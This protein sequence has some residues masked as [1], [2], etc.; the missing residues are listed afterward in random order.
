MPSV[1]KENYLKALYNLHQRN[2]E[3]SVSDLGQELEVSKPTVHDM[4]K[5]LE[6]QGWVDYQRYKP[7][8]L[9]K[10]GEKMA[11]LVIR[12]HRLAEMFLV[13]VM[14]FG[15][16]EVHN[17]AEEI[18][19]LK[20]EKLFDRMDEIMGFPSIDPHGSPIPDKDGNLTSPD[21]VL[22]NSIKPGERVVFR[23]LK[24]SSVDFLVYLN[25]KELQLGTTIH[26]QSIEPFDGSMVVD[27]GEYEGQVLTERVTKKLLV[28]G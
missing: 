4:V 9:T 23:A 15:W 2:A 7:L 3:I 28:E 17:M 8:K 11:A 13:Q 6:S 25:K 26:V 21:Y 12:K 10:E 20:S 22:L 27:Y 19:H 1:T 24:D 5:R 18:E 16:E 14:G